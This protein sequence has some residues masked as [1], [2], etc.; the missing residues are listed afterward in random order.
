MEKGFTQEEA[1]KITSKK[2]NYDKEATA[3][4]DKIEKYRD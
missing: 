4:Y 2:Y 1:H 3:F